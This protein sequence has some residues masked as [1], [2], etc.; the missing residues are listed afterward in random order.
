[1]KVVYL[2]HPLSAD[3][4]EGIQANRE[5][6]AQWCVWAAKARG[7]AVECSWIV[8]TGVLEETEENLKLGLAC[9][10]ALIER[11][12]ELWYVGGRISS[13]MKLEG[14]HAEVCRKPVFDLTHMGYR[15]PSIW[16]VKITMAVR[17][18]DRFENFMGRT[19]EA[20]RR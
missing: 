1:M 15:P 7:V 3:T 13:G 10:L 18:D 5:N 6:A 4:L 19:F 17:S 9:D 2:A 11:C 12:D 20:V 16:S 8:M 14:Q